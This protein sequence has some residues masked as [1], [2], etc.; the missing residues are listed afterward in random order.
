LFFASFLAVALTSQRFLN[1]TFFTGLQVK[2]V[3]F[4]FFNDVLLLDLAL[5]PAKRV[6]KRLTLLHTYFSQT[7][8]TSNLCQYG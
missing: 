4:Y 2:G 6:L 7:E 3:T 5:K 1:A 8:Y